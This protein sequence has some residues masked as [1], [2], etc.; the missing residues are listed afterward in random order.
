MRSVTKGSVK[1]TWIWGLIAVLMAV[2]EVQALAT[3]DAEDPVNW[4]A[5]AMAVLIAVAGY[6]TRDNDVSSEEAKG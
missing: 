5:I 2:P 4:V 1:T 6:F 3:R